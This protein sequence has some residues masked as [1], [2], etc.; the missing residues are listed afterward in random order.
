[1]KLLPCV[2]APMLLGL[3][4]AACTSLTA[5]PDQVDPRRMEWWSEQHAHVFTGPD[6]L[7]VENVFTAKR[8]SQ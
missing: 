1:M 7:N 4:L 6:S 8:A 5:A 3:L 2:S